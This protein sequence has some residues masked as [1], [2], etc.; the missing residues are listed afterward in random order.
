MSLLHQ[1]VQLPGA[2][3]PIGGGVNVPPPLP[4]I[5]RFGGNER[6]PIQS[7]TYTGA[8]VPH[9][10]NLVTGGDVQP[11]VPPVYAPAGG[12]APVHPVVAALAAALTG[13]HPPS[14][15]PIGGAPPAPPSAPPAAAGPHHTGAPP[16]VSLGPPQQH[17]GAPPIVSLGPPQTHGGGGQSLSQVIAALAQSGQK[18]NPGGSAHFI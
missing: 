1:L 16:I 18:Y 7:Q 10:L 4:P 9:P 8:T 13:I 15:A 3:S 5:L 17:T 6:G 2:V 14:P 12:T 11:F